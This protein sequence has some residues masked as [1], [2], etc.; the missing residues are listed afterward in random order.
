[1]RRIWILLALFTAGIAFAQSPE[2]FGRGSGGQLDLTFKALSRFSGSFGLTTG[3]STFGTFGGTLV[4]D[5]VW[6]FAA[7]EHSQ[8]TQRFDGNAFTS[9]G[10][11]NSAAVTLRAPDSART[12]LSLHYTGIVSSNSFFTA[13]ATS[14]RK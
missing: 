11:R 14:D 9:F 13:T 10:D 3:R 6:F 5:R 8:R 7:G 12:F 2:V 4:K 1:M